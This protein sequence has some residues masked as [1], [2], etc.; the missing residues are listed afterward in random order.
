MYKR[1]M[2]LGVL[3]MAFGLF[4]SCKMNAQ[5]DNGRQQRKERP[6]MEEL[7]KEMDADED[8]KL[9]KEEVKGPL[10]KD[11]TKIDSDEDGFLSKEEIENAPKPERGK[12]RPQGRQ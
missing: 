12:G 2:K 10:K 5:N 3:I 6:S 1:T 9:S 11:F 7:F 4:A 8:G